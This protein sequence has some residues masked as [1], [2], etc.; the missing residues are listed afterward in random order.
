MPS[1]KKKYNARFPPVS[2]WPSWASA[3]WTPGRLGPRSC[4]GGAGAFRCSRPDA[5]PPS[6]PYWPGASLPFSRGTPWLPPALLQGRRPRHPSSV[7]FLRQARIKKIMQTDEEI[8]KVAAAVP[9]II[10]ILL[11]AAGLRG[12]GRD[13]GTPLSRILLDTPQPG[14]LS[15]SWSPC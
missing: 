7:P 11:G 3:G 14:R 4:C 13:F 10:C 8:G 2:T 6:M 12:V 1:K 5:P 15:S 9:V